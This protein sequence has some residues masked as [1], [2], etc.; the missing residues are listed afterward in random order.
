MIR[1]EHGSSITIGSDG[2]GGKFGS[3]VRLR[4]VG[5]SWAAFD[6]HEQINVS[7]RG[8]VDGEQTVP[9]SELFALVHLLTHVRVPDGVLIEMHV[10]NAYVVNQLH[11]LVAGWRPGI[12]TVHGDLWTRAAATRRR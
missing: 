1:I 8:G 11:A 10:D 5:W 4:G 2:S 6:C 12:N 9:R 3:D 7:I